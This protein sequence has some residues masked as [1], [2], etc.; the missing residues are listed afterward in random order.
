MQRVI[1]LAEG[2]NDEA[3]ML[4]NTVTKFTITIADTFLYQHVYEEI[5]EETIAAN[6]KEPK[7]ALCQL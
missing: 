3:K 5:M 4:S 7:I 2:R 1:G 6:C